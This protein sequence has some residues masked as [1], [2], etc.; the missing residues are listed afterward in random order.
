MYCVRNRSREQAVK[1]EPERLWEVK[2]GFQGS[3]DSSP[4]SHRELVWTRQAFGPDFISCV[5]HNS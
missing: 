5:F 1:R 4:E 3:R 2:Q